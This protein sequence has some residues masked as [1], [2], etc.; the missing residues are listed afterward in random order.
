MWPAPGEW[1]DAVETNNP[2]VKRVDVTE[3]LTR[4]PRTQWGWITTSW[5]LLQKTL[6][7]PL[8]LGRTLLRHIFSRALCGSQKQ[9]ALLIV[10]V[11]FQM[12]TPAVEKCRCLLLIC[13]KNVCPTYKITELLVLENAVLLPLPLKFNPMQLKHRGSLHKGTDALEND[14]GGV[15]PGCE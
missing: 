7:G 13:A 2:G 6:P 5:L 1:V 14:F 8:A 3:K 4:K 12:R 15:F 9:H 11:L 10:L